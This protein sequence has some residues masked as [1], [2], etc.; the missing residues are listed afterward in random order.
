MRTCDRGF[1]R[2]PKGRRREPPGEIDVAVAELPVEASARVDLQRR[3]QIGRRSTRRRWCGCLQRGDGGL[4]LGEAGLEIWLP[5]EQI[6]DLRRLRLQLLEDAGGVVLRVLV[7]LVEV[8]FQRGIHGAEEDLASMGAVASFQGG[9]AGRKG[10]WKVSDTRMLGTN[11]E[12]IDLT[13]RYK[14]GKLFLRKKKAMKNKA[15]AES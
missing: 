15:A 1:R 5:S 10:W 2:G 12:P 3:R 9:A 8:L 13:H 4:E 6:I 7:Q 11:S 14:F